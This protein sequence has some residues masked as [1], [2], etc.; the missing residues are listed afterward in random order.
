MLL[1]LPP[2][3]YGSFV[4]KSFSALIRNGF[5]IACTELNY[6]YELNRFEDYESYLDRS[7]R[8]KALQA[9]SYGKTWLRLMDTEMS[10]LRRAIVSSA[11]L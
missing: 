3:P 2:T 6:A 7:A 8:K 10:G 11:V 9:L 5:R 4:A 1:V